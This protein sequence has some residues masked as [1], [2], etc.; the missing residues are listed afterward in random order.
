M[1]TKMLFHLTKHKNEPACKCWFGGNGVNEM[2][3]LIALIAIAFSV[4]NIIL[5]IIDLIDR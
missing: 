5:M 1:L 2:A 3:G 4:L